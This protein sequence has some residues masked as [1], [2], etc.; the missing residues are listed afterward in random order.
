MGPDLGSPRDADQIVM[1]K[2]PVMGLE[3]LPWL[4]AKKEPFLIVGDKHR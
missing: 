1:L 3:I 2:D 4:K